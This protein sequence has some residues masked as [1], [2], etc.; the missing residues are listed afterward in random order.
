[1]SDVKEAVRQ[2]FE[3]AAE[4]YRTSAVHAQGEDLPALVAAAALTGTESVL[5]AGCGAGHASLAVAPHA[6]AVTA[7]DLSDAMLGQVQRLAQDRGANNVRTQR[8]DVEQMPFEGGAF[9]VAISRYSAH[10]WPNPAAALRELYRVLKPGGRF[11]LS[12][13]VAPSAPALDTYLQTVE[14]LRDPS[15]VRDHTVDQWLQMFSA[16]GLQAEVVYEWRVALD[17]LPWLER[18]GTPQQ[19]AAMIAALLN[20]APSE[21]RAELEWHDRGTFALRG[22]LF[23]AI[24]R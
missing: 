21:V 16:A 14:L 9:E 5:D 1:M 6:A 17:F 7:L 15:H 4:R 11:V 18:I 3:A 12:D 20:G 10:H 2:Q 24:R 22:A 13:I 23:R 8:G 19:N